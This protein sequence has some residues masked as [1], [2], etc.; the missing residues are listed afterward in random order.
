[1]LE[2]EKTV[3]VF[4]DYEGAKHKFSVPSYSELKKAQKNLLDNIEKADEVIVDSLVSW[5]VSREV[6]DDF[7]LAH[8]RKLWDAVLSSKKD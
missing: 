1:M 2:F 3:I 6:L 4:K 8:I 7:E 5:G